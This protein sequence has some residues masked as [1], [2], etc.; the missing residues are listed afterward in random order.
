MG[1]PTIAIF[2]IAVFL[3]C[4]AL[5]LLSLI[6]YRKNCYDR[7][8]SGERLLMREDLSGV[9]RDFVKFVV[10]RRTGAKNIISSIGRVPKRVFSKKDISVSFPSEIEELWNDEQFN[11]FVKNDIKVWLKRSPVLSTVFFLAIIL[12]LIVLGISRSLKGAIPK[13]SNAGK[14][15]EMKLESVYEEN[16]YGSFQEAA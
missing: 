7:A 3:V 12:C 14:F 5:N 6:R 15:Y 2:S 8:F 9:Q 10:N 13:I 16:T 11:E 1:V 4:I